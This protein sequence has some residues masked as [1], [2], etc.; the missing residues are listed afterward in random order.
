MALARGLGFG[1]VAMVWALPLGVLLAWALCQMINPRAF[2][3]T[4][5]LRFDVAAVARLAAIGLAAAALAAV[6]PGWR[7]ARA[8]RGGVPQ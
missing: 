5:P 4:I 2:G 3:W 1:L 8:G 6:L 7:S